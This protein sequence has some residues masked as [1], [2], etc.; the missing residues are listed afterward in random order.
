MQLSDFL[1]TIVPREG[2]ENTS[3]FNVVLLWWNIN[4][5]VPVTDLGSACRTHNIW[6]VSAV[7]AIPGGIH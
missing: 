2:L 1:V 7:N 3:C 4:D 6:I 5:A